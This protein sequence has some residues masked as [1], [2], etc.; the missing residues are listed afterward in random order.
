MMEWCNSEP[1]I[2]ERL[3]SIEIKRSTGR[4]PA[5]LSVARG[6][7]SNKSALVD[8]LTSMDDEGFSTLTRDSA[9]KSVVMDDDFL[10]IRSAEL[11]KTKSASS[12]PRTA[13][14]V[15]NT[16]KYTPSSPVKRSSPEDIQL[17][18]NM[19]TD[20]KTLSTLTDDQLE[21]F[22]DDPYVEKV[23]NSLAFSVA[24]KSASPSP[25]WHNHEL[26]D[27]VDEVFVCR[28]KRI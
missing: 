21:E 14:P 26:S 23:T 7:L 13:T 8:Y 28:R 1:D 25:K 5:K 6:L 24:R 10:S 11:S 27:D 18:G 22:M 20:A 4:S 2:R 15:R 19:R 3:D 9:I 16:L 17:T 12:P